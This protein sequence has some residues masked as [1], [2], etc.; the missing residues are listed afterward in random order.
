VKT[1][2]QRAF[3]SI[4]RA[5]HMTSTVNPDDHQGN[6]EN[7]RPRGRAAGIVGGDSPRLSEFSVQRSEFSVQVSAFRIQNSKFP[8]LR[9]RNSKSAAR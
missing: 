4:E 3:F 2:P 1:H 7:I 9:Y 8:I 6:V 5:S